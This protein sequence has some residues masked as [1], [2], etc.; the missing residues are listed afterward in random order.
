MFCNVSVIKS[1]YNYHNRDNYFDNLDVQEEINNKLDEM[2]ESGE[3]EELLNEIITKSQPNKIVFMTMNGMK[4]G[5]NVK[6]IY[7]LCV[8]KCV[9]IE[10]R[11]NLQF[12]KKNEF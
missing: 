7:Y 2:V 9:N 10:S 12:V 8:D 11:L 5:V 4:K 1:R 6:I 3:F